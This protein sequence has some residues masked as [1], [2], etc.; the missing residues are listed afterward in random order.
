MTSKDRAK[1]SV[2]LSRIPKIHPLCMKCGKGV[3]TIMS[4]AYADGYHR[5]HACRDVLCGYKFYSLTPYNGR[6]AQISPLP[7]QDRPLSE[8]EES[9]RMQWWAEEV[10]HSRVV[11]PQVTQQGNIK[12]DA[13]LATIKRIAMA[14]LKPKEMRTHIDDFLVDMHSA[15]EEELKTLD[16]EKNENG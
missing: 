1:L 3:R 7:F 9:M 12:D 15:I 14:I 16:K 5:R 13:R 2:P 4:Q 11:A 6:P 10:E 8:A